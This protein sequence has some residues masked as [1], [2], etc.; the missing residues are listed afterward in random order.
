MRLWFEKRA[1][2]FMAGYVA[3]GMAR[4]SPGG[5]CWGGRDCRNGLFCID[6]LL[7]GTKKTQMAEVNRVGLRTATLL[8]RNWFRVKAL[9]KALVEQRNISGRKATRIIE[10]ARKRGVR[11]GNQHRN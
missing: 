8:A 3:E 9:T 11:H 4:P 6:S 7:I 10:T 2:I 5:I 1:M